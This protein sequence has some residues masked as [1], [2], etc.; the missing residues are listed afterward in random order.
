[1]SIFKK[2]NEKLDEGWKLTN[3]NCPI[4]NVK[5]FQNHD[6]FIRQVSLAKPTQNNF[7]V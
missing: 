3:V 6:S 5:F 4:C 2:I 7:T 1:M